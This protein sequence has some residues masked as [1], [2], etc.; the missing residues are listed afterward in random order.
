MKR[1]R[2]NPRGRL[3]KGLAAYLVNM[4]LICDALGL[5]AAH[6][7]SDQLAKVAL[8]ELRAQDRKT[9]KC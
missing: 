7:L 1:K 5:T 3:I 8:R 6:K 2:P 4:Q 9:R